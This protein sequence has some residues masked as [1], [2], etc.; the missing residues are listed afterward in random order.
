MTAR[1]R[2]PRPTDGFIYV[3]RPLISVDGQEVVKI[4]MTTRTVAQRVRELTT[5][6]M[7]GFE[8]LYSLHVENARLF[9]KQLHTRYRTNR[10]RGGGQEFFCVSARD[11][12]AEIEK[13]ATEISKSRARQVRDE[14]ISIFSKQ[15]G[16]ARI[17]TMIAAPMG[18][19]LLLW[20]LSIWLFHKILH[21]TNQGNSE[22]FTLVFAL[23]IYLPILCLILGLIYHFL[24]LYFVER[25]FGVA[26]RAKHLELRRKYPLAY[27]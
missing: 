27:S 23:F 20:P 15:I 11:V 18:L 4:G 12:I 21:Y 14:E 1:I 17:E 19:F 5:G 16:A 10:F 9:E 26:I 8:I 6:S 25:R 13:I 22:I 7:V 3:L 24:H 2:S